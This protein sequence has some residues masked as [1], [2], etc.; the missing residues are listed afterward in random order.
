MRLKPDFAWI[1]E[2]KVWNI[3]D[4][5]AKHVAEGA[6]KAGLPVNHGDTAQVN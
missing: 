1:D 6:K 3:P 4:A 5:Y 2:V